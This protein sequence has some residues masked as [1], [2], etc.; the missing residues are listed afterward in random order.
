MPNA[1]IR[2]SGKTILWGES[3]DRWTETFFSEPV[4]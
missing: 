4:S 3:I 1:A 2:G